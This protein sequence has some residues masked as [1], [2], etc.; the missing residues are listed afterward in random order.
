[1]ARSEALYWNI[2]PAFAQTR[3]EVIQLRIPLKSPPCG[4]T[5]PLDGDVMV[6]SAKPSASDAAGDA[7]PMGMELVVPLVP[8][9]TDAHGCGM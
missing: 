7:D 4:A 8:D 3:I 2:W 9:A 1:L 5:P 6:R